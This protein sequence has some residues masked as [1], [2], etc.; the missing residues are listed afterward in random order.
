MSIPKLTQR[1][2]IKLVER[3]NQNRLLVEGRDDKKFFKKLFITLLGKDCC[4]D[5]DSVEDFVQTDEVNNRLKVESICASIQDKPYSRKL[6]GFVDREFRGFA[7]TENLSDQLKCHQVN[8]QIVWSRGHSIENYFFDLEVLEEPIK[9]TMPSDYFKLAFDMF[10]KRISQMLKISCAISI[11]AHEQKCIKKITN[12]ICWDM[13]EINT[14]NIRINI[15]AWAKSLKSREMSVQEIERFLQAF[16]RAIEITENSDIETV[17]WTCHGHLGVSLI[18]SLYC[19]CVYEVT[20]DFSDDPTKET[21]LVQR[22]SDEV[23][24]EACVSGWIEKELSHPK[25]V[26]LEVLNLLGIN[27]LD[28]FIGLPT[29]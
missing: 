13:I 16:G 10:K 25:C 6:V 9:F 21:R 7:I 11:A 23:R 1:E 14:N 22:V 8:G 12:T 3:S 29:I 15:E 5:I 28:K 26:P 24:F 17:R 4:I 18:W 20:K 19:R 2:Y 27:Q